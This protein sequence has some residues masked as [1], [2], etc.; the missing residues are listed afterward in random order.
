M[1]EHLLFHCQQC[2]EKALKAVWSERREDEPLRT[3]S[4]PG[5]AHT[6]GLRLEAAQEKLLHGLDRLY[7]R[8]RYPDE[9]LGE[10]LDLHWYL[11]Q[12]QELYAWLRQQLT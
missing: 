1:P 9:P 8:T 12:T 4:L 11:D 7:I 6:L 5:L 10:G 3:H 2:V